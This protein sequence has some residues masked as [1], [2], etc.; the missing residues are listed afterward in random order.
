[1]FY[2]LC[3]MRQGDANCVKYI[4]TMLIY[5]GGGGGG[6]LTG[7]QKVRATEKE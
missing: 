7:G 3:I 4:T 5:K 2:W 6:V 1:M